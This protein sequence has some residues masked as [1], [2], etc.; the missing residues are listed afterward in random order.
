VGDLVYSL[1]QGEVVTVPIVKTNQTPVHNHEVVQVSLENGAVL[2]ISA[3]HPTAEGR[4][5]GDLAPQE[6]IGGVAIRDV[7]AIA[8]QFE[9]TYDILPDSDTGA[10]F[11][12]GVPIGS[13]LFK[14]HVENHES[15]SPLPRNGRPGSPFHSMRGVVGVTNGIR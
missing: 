7:R 6:R 9:Y 15:P 10:Y 4:V 1:H 14:G 2:E 5:V 11:T 13:T 3:L 8:Y 12:G